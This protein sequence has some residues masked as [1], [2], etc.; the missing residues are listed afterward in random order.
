MFS[1]AMN[2]SRPTSDKITPPSDVSNQIKCS[3]CTETAEKLP[4]VPSSGDFHRCNHQVGVAS[5]PQL[6]ISE[7]DLLN[8]SSRSS[9]A[10]FDTTPPDPTR[11]Q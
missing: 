2:T 5:S 6:V 8:W 3:Q 11:T 9:S 7:P 4:G 1:V 10:A